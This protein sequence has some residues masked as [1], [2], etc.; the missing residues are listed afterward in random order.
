LEILSTGPTSFVTF[1]GSATLAAADVTNLLEGKLYLQLH[2][3]QYRPGAARAQ[4]ILPHATTM[5]MTAMPPW[6]A[7]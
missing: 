1:S 4:L 6:A 5:T 2:T 7:P 3:V